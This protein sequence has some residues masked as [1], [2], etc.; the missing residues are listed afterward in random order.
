MC[1]V[2]S[3][4]GGLVGRTPESSADSSWG[5]GL[6]EP[7]DSLHKPQIRRSLQ[8]LLKTNIIL[9]LNI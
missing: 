8:V 9:E 4:W 1:K 3:T 5:E 7:T 6:A 2:P